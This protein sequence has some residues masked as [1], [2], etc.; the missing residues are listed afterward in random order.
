MTLLS[1]MREDYDLGQ[2]D[3]AHVSKD[4]M[5]QFNI[6]MDD[7]KQEDILEP[8][9]MTLSTVTKD[10]YPTSRIVLL[11]GLEEDGFLFYTNYESDKALQIR[12]NAHVALVF[13]WKKLQRQVRIMGTAAKISK[14]KSEAYFHSRPKDNQIGAWVSPQSQIIENKAVLSERKQALIE[15]YKE[16][17]Q[18]PLPDFWGGYKVRPHQMEFWQGRPSRLHDR[19]RYTRIENEWKLERLAP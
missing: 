19:L 12:E 11:K 7:A 3:E 18:L 16:E 6:W 5:K 10:G 2:L 8:N 13:L 17:D 14:E 15:K 4:A 1:D 9:A